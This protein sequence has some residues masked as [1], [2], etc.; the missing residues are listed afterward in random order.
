MEKNEIKLGVGLPI[1]NRFVDKDF[2]LSFAVC[3]AN[4]V[5]NNVSCVLCAPT[6]DIYD[7]AENIAK[8][9]NSL[10]VNAIENECTHLVML[11]TDQLY[12]P[13]TLLKMINHNVDVVG[14][15]VHRRYP[16]FAPVLY[17]GKLHRYKNV[18][19]EEAYSGNLIEVDATGTGC[20]LYNMDVFKVIDPPWFELVPGKDGKP[21]GEDIRFCSKLKNAGFKIYVDTSIQLDHLTI[22]RVNRGTYD[23]FR[24]IYKPNDL[25]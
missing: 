11:D 13:D 20:I 9:R 24:K 4:A 21:V 2:T 10:V 5:A 15:L 25:E 7:Y 14:A 12:F 19:Y 1:T 6:Q 16:P 23:L 8:I 18:P 17:R 3:M 22:F